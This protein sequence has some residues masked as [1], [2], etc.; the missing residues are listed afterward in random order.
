MATVASRKGFSSRSFAVQ[1][2]AF[3]GQFLAMSARRHSDDQPF[4]DVTAT[5]LCDPPEAL[6][7]AAGFVER[8][9]PQ[10]SGQIARGLELARVANGGND[11]GGCNRSD[12]WYAYQPT[13][14]GIQPGMLFDQLRQP[15]DS[16]IEAV[17]LMAHH[18]ENA[19]RDLWHL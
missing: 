16:S 6:S 1:A 17:Q 18:A 5:L 10:P 3:P 4:S 19:V 8:G 15:V 13:R 2:S 14:I 12:A 11:G 9:Q 7:P